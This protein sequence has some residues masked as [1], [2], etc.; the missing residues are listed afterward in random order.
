[1][2][3][4]VK[5]YE[6]K[7]LG[8]PQLEKE[9]KSIELMLKNITIAKKELN[10]VKIDP[11]DVKKLD[12][13]KIK[14]NDAKIKTA[15]LRLERQRLMNEMRANQN[16]QQT[17][18]NQQK[19]ANAAIIAEVGSLTDL[20]AKRKQLKALI[21]ATAENNPNTHPISFDG[22]AYTREGALNHV[23]AIDAEV[24]RLQGTFSSTQSFGDRMTQS[25]SN[26]FRN[27][28]GQLSQLTLTYLGWFAAFQQAGKFIEENIKLS[29][30]FA[31]L[32]IR[33]KGTTQDVNKLFDD[34]KKIDSR[35]SLASLVDIANIVAKKGVDKDEIAG[36]TAEFDKLNV[37]LGHE[38]GEP[39]TAA[40]N[41]IKLITIFNDDKHVTKERVA[42]IG[43]ALFKLTTSG[44]ATGEFLVNFAERVGAVRGITGLTLPSILG[45]GAALQQLGQRTE[46]A[47]TAA[48]QLTTKLFTD[49][50]KFAKAAK[51][52]V[53]EFRDMLARDPFE[54]LVAVA[55]GLK[56][57]GG[58]ELHANF[59]EV[60]TAFGEVGV[61]GVRI[62]AVLGDIATNGAFVRDRMKQAAVNSADYA[63]QTAALELKQHTL[64]A[65]IDRVKKA[66]EAL[67]TNRGIQIVFAA[68]GALVLVLANSLGFLLPLITA[69]GVV[70]SIANASMIQARIGTFLLNAQLTIQY[71]A[72]VI[73]STFQR[74]YA[75]SLAYMTGATN[76]ATTATRL[77][78]IAL[79][80]LPIGLLITL[81]A[82]LAASCTT[83]ANKVEGLSLSLRR[84]AAAQQAVID[85]TSKANEAIAENIAQ[86]DIQAAIITSTTSSLDTQKEALAKLAEQHKIFDTI[87]LGNSNSLTQFK[88]VLDE[89]K[90]AMRA[91]A[92]AQAAQQLSAEKYNDYL[93]V[94]KERQ[95][96]ERLG[97]DP[98]NQV[99]ISSGNAIRVPNENE[100][101]YFGLGIVGTK[102]YSPSEFKSKVEELKKMEKDKFDT[103]ND[104][105]LTASGY[106]IKANEAVKTA[107]GLDVNGPK[108]AEELKGMIKDINNQLK[109]LKEGDAKIAEL[110]KTRAE[111]QKRL[112]E[113]LNKEP[114]IPTFKEYRGARLG[115]DDKD[116]LSII[117]SRLKT[118]M[119]LEDKRFLALQ[120]DHRLTA[121]EELQH[122][123]NIRQIDAKYIKEKILTFENQKNLNAKEKE[124]L[125]NFHKEKLDIELK[126]VNDSQAIRDKE[127]T[128]KANDLKKILDRSISDINLDTTVSSNDQSLTNTQRAQIK[129]DNDRKILS[130]Q[131]KYN[132]DIDNLEKTLNQRT[133]E[134]T[135]QGAKTR[136][137]IIED[138]ILIMNSRFKDAAES[139]ESIAAQFQ[140]SAA[141]QIIKILDGNGSLTSKAREIDKV[142]RELSRNLL[143]N[144]IAQ[145]KIELELYK[146]GVSEKLKSEKEYQEALAKLKSS[147]AQLAIETGE[148]QTSALKKFTQALKE[149]KDTVKEG[150][151]KITKY[152][153]S[154]E[155]EAQK[156]ADAIKQSQ[157]TISQALEEGYENYF[158]NQED[159]IDLE[160]DV[161]ND[162]LDREQE[163][164]KA[165]AQSQAEID[166]I[167]AQYAAKKKEVD[168]KAGEEKKKLALKQIA[169][170]YALA[171]VKALAQY[172]L[173]LALIPIAASTALYF[174]QK[175]GIQSQQFEQGGEVPT[176]GGRFGGRRH[177]QGGT[178]F[179][180]KGREYN[181]EV[182]ELAIIRTK[183]ASPNKQYTIS[184]TQMQIA[185]KLNK[186]GGGVEF[187]SG[188]TMGRG[189]DKGG[190]LGTRYPAPSY[191]YNGENLSDYI[192]EI[193]N[194]AIEQS[195]RIDRLEVY[196]VTSTVS[197]AQ[198]KQVKQSQI[199]VLA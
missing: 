119:A 169:I 120:L 157:D 70:W 35:T 192:N 143:I 134:N 68:I 14:L 111:L 84:K 74:A 49:V 181:A 118:E 141:D 138:S 155:G 7:T 85:I 42:E 186:L 152:E 128:R 135:L 172:G 167:D 174:V 18:I 194:L 41:I 72:L 183:N 8:Y 91:N 184:G 178:D 196:Q 48:V 9:L 108:T 78:N 191:N 168:R 136:Q 30:S 24:R 26:G 2:G 88:A 4:I 62:K 159:R 71:A 107:P 75:I 94:I 160:R 101:D 124:T 114:K 36:L 21:S 80:L 179:R 182:D 23:R 113:I 154:P 122:I 59:E 127:Y 109:V 180:F 28:R 112:A 176:K 193:R 162:R 39:A 147:E 145:Q 198:K 52:S 5:I 110:R 10:R 61:T 98:R 32:Q 87:I 55:E 125:A 123:E 27:M 58:E 60:V 93:K 95:D 126:A 161:Q 11:D 131:E 29:D 132:G 144:Q 34:L 13:L 100:N 89:V 189:F 67:A 73:A 50:P 97:A 37:V 22:A 177:S 142:Q 12:E 54:A 31:D 99:K 77:L 65:T 129:L 43:T 92:E 121:E 47:G 197:N 17:Q 199:G 105:I 117:E 151:F 170:D 103:Y 171:V 19:A 146:K 1:M 3:N 66:F 16:I 104:F 115:G 133:K 83:A 76:G 25:I 102:Y 106:K 82:F 173:P 137:Q 164:V 165:R 190:I 188:A 56:S 46:V 63:N 79:R 40:A 166:S 149:F 15:E 57:L 33:I 53:E 81:I 38:M 45:M 90:G 44:V 139:A 158:R 64:A 116:E 130:L 51:I 6:V 156:Q 185:S 153:D 148:A 195:N 175:A 69:Y 150:I 20:I 86:M 96:L 140:A 163:L 187:R